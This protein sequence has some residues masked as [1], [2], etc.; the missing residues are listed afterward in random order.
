MVDGNTAMPET[1]FE[2]MEFKVRGKAMDGDDGYDLSSV[3][4]SLSSFENLIIKTYLQA[5][6]K[7]RFTVV[8]KSNIEIKLKNVKKV[9]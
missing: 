7:Q 8:D 6:G 5:N 3:V 2:T 9:P 4:Q 1:I